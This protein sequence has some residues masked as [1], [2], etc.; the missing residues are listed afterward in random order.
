MTD[1][2]SDYSTLITVVASLFAMRIFLPSILR[3]LRPK[4]QSATTLNTI[5]R[6]KA[7]DIEAFNEVQWAR[8]Q[9]LVNQEQLA[10]KTKAES[11]SGNWMK[12][13]ANR[14]EI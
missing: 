12:A 3:P 10:L 14:D 4:S 1:I 5:N 11:Q 7:E 8:I 13:F 2:L 6:L 9:W